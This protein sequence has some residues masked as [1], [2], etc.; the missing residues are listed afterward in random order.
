VGPFVLRRLLDSLPVI[1]LALMII[2]A[3]LRLAPG[4]P[5][6]MLAGPDPSSAT[7]AAIREAMGLDR[8][9]PAQF[10]LWLRAA[11]SGDLGLSLVNGLPVSELVGDRI[12]PTVE[13]AI[14]GLFLSLVIGLTTGL[15]AGLRPGS[16][17]DRLVSTFAS[18]GLATP[19]FW[20]GILLIIVFGLNMRWFPVAGRTGFSDGVFEAVRSLAL[21]ALTL[22]IGNAP[23]IARFL[24]NSIIE[25]RKS[26]HVLTA[27]SKGLPMRLVVRDYVLRNSLIPVVTA[28]GI[29][30]GNLVGGTALVEIVFSWPGLGSLLINAI[31]NR[32]YSVVQGVMVVVVAGFLLS[33]ILVDILYGVLDPRI[34]QVNH[35]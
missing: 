16:L 13:L 33:S 20:S 9:I 10:I 19:K 27:M 22:A 21:P 11:L 34:R 23:I 30:L 7:I 31:G 2:F 25:A 14:A 35:G 4:D 26:D 1:L 29:I 18:L 28:A 12:G 3:G 24:R 15:A 32:D 6:E 17:T 8:S 5:A